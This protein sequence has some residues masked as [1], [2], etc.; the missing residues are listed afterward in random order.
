MRTIGILQCRMGSSRLQGKSMLPLAGKPMCTNI[1]ERLLD[2]VSFDE[3]VVAVPP[4]KDDLLIVAE[5]V[6][7]GINVF[8][9]S[10]DDLIDRY[11]QCAKLFDAE[12]VVRLCGDN[13]M[14][15]PEEVDRIIDYAERKAQNGILYS[16]TENINNNRY[17]DGLGAEVYTMQTLEWMHKNLKGE[18]YR[19]HPHKYF[20]DNGLVETIKCPDEFAYPKIKLDINTGMDYQYIEAIYN[21]VGS[22]EF[23]ITDYVGGLM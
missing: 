4:T 3:L 5:A 1:M 10:E 16:N 11:Y 15:E 17:P 12:L 19:E 8:V 14:K 2:V 18:R 22:N 23:H 6:K 13:P 21:K 20:H 7:L 9:G